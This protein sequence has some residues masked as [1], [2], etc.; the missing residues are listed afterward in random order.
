MVELPVLVTIKS[1]LRHRTDQVEF[2]QKARGSWFSQQRLLFIEARLFWHG[3]VNR[4]DLVEH[5]AI[6]RSV[7]SEDLA[8]YRRV[9]PRNAVYDRRSKVYR[10][11]RGFIPIFGP[12]GMA[13]LLAHSLLG[14]G[15][16][17]P[18]ASFEAIKTPSR[19]ADPVVARNIIAAAQRGFALKVFYRSMGTPAGRWPW[20]EPHSLVSN[21]FRWHV[22]AFCRERREFRDFVLGRMEQADET[23]P[24][25]ANPES[26][27]RWHQLIEVEIRPH[28]KLTSEQ[29][30]LVGLDYGMNDGLARFTC[31][32]ALLWYALIN[33]GLDEERSPPRQLLELADPSVITL[34]GFGDV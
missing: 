3:R 10:A 17:S 34:A 7:A 8:E 23:G 15:L 25:T 22:R 27:T 21:G 29:A 12:P 33:L 16:P 26:D 19:A 5:F 24:L 18:G 31:R 30:V 13:G 28:R 9:A 6:H 1:P 11:G 20:I 4:S 14:D 2:S 32:Q